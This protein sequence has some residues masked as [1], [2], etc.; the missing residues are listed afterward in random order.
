M[1]CEEEN[2]GVSVYVSLYEMQGES[3]I[4]ENVHTIMVL[5][6][7]SFAFAVT[8]SFGHIENLLS[9]C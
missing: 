2:N 9:S 5:Y 6:A 3:A 1:M 8:D 7:N 4:G